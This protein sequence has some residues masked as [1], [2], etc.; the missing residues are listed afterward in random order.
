MRDAVSSGERLATPDSLAVPPP[1]SPRG[2]VLGNGRYRT[3]ITASGTG[4]AWLGEEALT[5]WRGDRVEDDDGWFVYVRDLADG[6]FWSLGDRPVP[7]VAE[8]HETEDGP[9]WMGFARRDHGIESRM[10]VWVDADLDAECRRI[11]F[12]NLTDRPRTLDVTSYLEVVLHD[13]RHHAAHPGFS[14]LFVQTQFLPDREVLAARRRPRGADEVHPWLVHAMRGHGLLSHESDRGRFLGRGRG[15][16]APLALVSR[17]PLSGT[18]GDVLDPALALRRIVELAPGATARLDLVLAAAPSRDEA[19]AIAERL[20]EA[21]TFDASRERS[22]T[23]ATGRLTEQGLNAGEGER[24][25]RLAAAMLYGDPALRAQAEAAPAAGSSPVSRPAF[26]LR[27]PVVLV[28]TGAPAA[29]VEHARTAHAYWRSIGLA[30]T[31]LI[32]EDQT[33]A[34]A[35]GAGA[36][37]GILVLPVGGLDA[38]DLAALRTRADLVVSDRFPT[39]FGTGVVGPGA[40]VPAQATRDH[41]PLAGAAIAVRPLEWL[42]GDETL[43]CFNGWGGFNALGDEYVIRMPRDD[44]GAPRLTPRPWIN[45]LANPGFGTLISESG[46][47]CT[48][49]RNSRELRITPWSN[50]P[51]RDPHDEALY[52]RDEE[53]GLLWSAFPGPNPGD[54]PYEMRHGFGY[55]RCRH[56]S[57]GI[58]VETEVFVHDSDPVKVVQVRISNPGPR[59]RRLSVTSYQRLVLG[60]DPVRA[61]QGVSTW[62]DGIEGILFAR[63][64]GSAEFSD[65]VAFAASVV[66]GGPSTVATGTDRERFLGRGGSRARPA[67]LLA[68]EG[69]EGRT[70]A[71]FEPCFRQQVSLD[72]GP[73]GSVTCAFLLGEAP[74]IETIEALVRRL[75]RPGA[76]D[77]AREEVVTRWKERVGRLQIETPVE[78]LDLMVNGW[79]AYQTLACRLWARTAFYQSGGA[80]GFRDQLQDAAA[81][82]TTEPRITRDQILLHCAHQFVEGDV[83]HWWHPPHGQGIRTRFADDLLWLP[84][85]TAAYVGTTGDSA[86]LDE[87]APFLSARALEPQEDE[88]LL[89]PMASGEVATV[90]EHCCRAIDRSL[91]TGSHGLPLFGS[92]DWNDGMNRVG[93]EGRGESVWM[94]FFLHQVIA[95]FAPLCEG[96]GDAE[97]AARWR[98]HQGRL[99][100]ALER[101]GWDGEWYRRG[102]YDD[103]TPLGSRDSD[104]CRIDAL[105]QAWSVLSGAALR[106]RSEQAMDA[107]ERELVSWEDGLVRL[108]SPPFDRTSHDP[109]YIKGYVPGVRENGGQYTHAALWVVAAMARLGRREQAARLLALLSPVSHSGSPADAERYQVEPYVVSA[110]VYGNP[111]HLGR[112]GWTWYTGSSGWML[113]ITLE[114]VLGVTVEGGDTLVVRAS[115]PP[116]WP[117]FRLSLRPLGRSGTC[118]V[119]IRNTSGAAAEVVGVTLDGVPIPPD[120]GIARVPLPN[121]G[122]DHDVHV[123]LQ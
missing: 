106:E 98:A 122:L 30:T 37:Q 100:E 93:R 83:L 49:S 10:D 3:L 112:G 60:H 42:W 62:A 61:G 11:T 110:D 89:T 119:E 4:G 79:L 84:F 118:T 108:L 96:R 71:G 34:T 74:A 113:R 78:S 81:F 52:L 39:G 40:A 94:A 99:G 5:S 82:L 47:G 70:G 90:Y 114:S 91:S 59:A 27:G 26:P 14:K 22:L 38:R 8:E 109:G 43:R 92:G 2:R 105:V 44:S 46:A 57:A 88:A 69:P 63:D 68:G 123:D 24:L 103:G 28:E 9:G 66:P 56:A 36:D 65:A 72:I 97:R 58:E 51:V 121:D 77:A 20:G 87:P 32:L 76:I 107:M 120:A 73:G 33:G 19:L 95:D 17:A 111:Q 35:D 45:V 23:L 55:S 117:G 85:V 12:H 13:P 54:G 48:W 101:A 1:A 67:A 7:V 29:A 116:T 64:A 25:E 18:T 31:L 15:P 104:E 6:R 16:D 115:I 75:R 50:D 53:S 41:A 86:L 80:F 21:G 102:Y